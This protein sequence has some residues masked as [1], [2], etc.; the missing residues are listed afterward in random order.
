VIAVENTC[1]AEP[2]PR[3]ARR[4]RPAA[5][6]AAI[7]A[8]LVLAVR[9][10]A[11]AEREAS[12]LSLWH[13]WSETDEWAA[14]A[15]A[16]RIASGN[17]LDVPAYRP[18]FAWQ[19]RFGTEAEWNATLPK[20]VYYQGPAYPYVLALA[21]VPREEAV[22]RLRLG[23]HLLA[24]VAA[25]FLA[26]AAAAILAR[27]GRP[28]LLAAVA[29]AAAGALHG[30]FGPLVFLDGF[31]YRDGPVAHAAALLLALPLLVERPPGPVKAAGFGLLAGTAALLKQTVLPLGL[32][33]GAALVLRVPRGTPRTRAAGGF[34]AGLLLALSPLVARNLAVGAPPFAFDTR[35]LVGIPWANARGADGSGS[36]SPHALRVLREAGGSTLAA[37]AGTLRTWEGD[38][39]GLPALLARKLVSA[40]QR[41]EIADDA[42]FD[43]F[44]LRL[45]V[46][47]RLPLFVCLL[48]PGV[49]G[50]VFAARR[51]L[52]R[53]GE[54]L[55]FAGAALVPLGAC[56]LVSTT[57][58]YRSGAAAPLAV[59]TALLLA[60]VL[61][62]V[63]E[64]RACGAVIP[65]GAAALLTA[66][67]F[68]PAAVPVRR[69]RW[70]DAVVAATLAEAK[71]SPEAGAAEV[72]RY[73]ADSADDMD[74]AQG[75]R[76]LARWLSGERDWTL[77]DS[78]A[79][80][81]PDRRYVAPAP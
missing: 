15:T 24:T 2:S 34:L 47:A 14:I 39:L 48:G 60:L 16:R 23:Q 18:Y 76:A 65:L 73:L 72:R 8:A 59:G 56:V 3:A 79:V 53:R 5:V 10:A 64:G 57:T 45:P 30:L 50:L 6:A 70:A 51:G 35:P 13:H 61:E 32:L 4:G 67:A 62:E 63:R 52:F 17:L 33:A 20:N 77:V 26:A 71:V 43:F 9:L 31:L 75:R 74:A 41:T 78:A 27:A 58:R 44:R 29:G 40:F 28:P 49:T 81:P 69:V 38:P 7:A 25:A 11:F 68:L 21:G 55:L 80:A 66:A 46:L 12:P 36:V 1:R 22:P 42:S 19:R 54:G 37:A